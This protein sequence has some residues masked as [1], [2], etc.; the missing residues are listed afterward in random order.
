MEFV[1]LSSRNII[2]K[3]WSP[4]VPFTPIPHYPADSTLS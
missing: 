2:S 1:E 4:A 3:N